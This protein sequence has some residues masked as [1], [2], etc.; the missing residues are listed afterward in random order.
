MGRARREAA[1]VAGEGEEGSGGGERRGERKEVA[2]AARWATR[3]ARRRREEA[4]REGG[5]KDKEKGEWAGREG[6]WGFFIWGYF[7]PR[8][9]LWAIVLLLVRTL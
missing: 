9:P 4:R 7:G 2:A 1:T 5:R 6:I 3:R 8:H